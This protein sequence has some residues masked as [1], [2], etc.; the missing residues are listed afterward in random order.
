MWAGD[1]KQRTN[2]YSMVKSINYLAQLFPNTAN[3]VGKSL[4]G[5]VALFR[6]RSTLCTSVLGWLSNDEYTL[7]VKLPV[8]RYT[9]GS[10]VTVI[11]FSVTF[12]T[13]RLVGGEGGA[14]V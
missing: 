8:P 10:Q 9:G 5:I 3:I 4:L 11:E 7:Y 12:T 6:S 2:I 1:R 13:L 14:A